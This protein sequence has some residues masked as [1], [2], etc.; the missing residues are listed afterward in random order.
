MQTQDIS[1]LKQREIEAKIAAAIINGY[2]REIGR[3]KALKIAADV[4][5]NLAREAGLQ[6]A[7]LRGANTISELALIVR[8]I[9]SEDKALE[10]EFLE[11][12]DSKL[13]FNVIRCRFA[14]L[15][16]RLGLKDLGYYFSCNRDG[17]FIQG[18]NPQI[19]L[20]RTNTI[21]EGAQFCDF[22]FKLE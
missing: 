8:E 10:V 16:E 5:Q 6:T 19:K 12:S 1:L 7:K 9:W 15:Y 3:E 13:H 22:R 2:A 14:D 17:A 11:E 20:K 18:F 4:I 21:M